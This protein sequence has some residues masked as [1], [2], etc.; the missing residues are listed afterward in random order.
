MLCVEPRKL[1]TR[2]GGGGGPQSYNDVILRL[3][4][5]SS[6]RAK[7]TTPHTPAQKKPRGRSGNS[8]AGQVRARAWGPDE[9]ARQLDTR[10]VIASNKTAAES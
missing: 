5:A 2:M 8:T 6:Y 3:A 1:L 9:H 7:L 4:K 10:P